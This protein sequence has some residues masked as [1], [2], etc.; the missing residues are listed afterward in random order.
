MDNLQQIVVQINNTPDVRS[1]LQYGTNFLPESQIL[2]KYDE[3]SEEEKKIW[4]NFINM[5]TNKV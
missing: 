2:I 5:L 1:I 3:L 4:D